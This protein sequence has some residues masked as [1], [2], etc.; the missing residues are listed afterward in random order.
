MQPLVFTGSSEM[1]F[2]FG[3]EEMQS[4]NPLIIMIFVPI[5]TLII[6][7]RIGRWAAPLRRMGCGIILAGV[8]YACVAA[9][10]SLL[11]AGYHL[12]ILWQSI[13]YLVLTFSE[14]LVSTT[15]LEYAYTAAGKNLKSI[16]SGF[17]FLTSTLGNFL[18][19]FLTA[20]VA[21]PASTSTFLI[22][23]SLS[24]GVGI[25]FFVVTSRNFFKTN[26]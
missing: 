5:V 4:V 2:S 20:L 23:A 22:Y 19:I 26:V 24:V 6:Y 10:Q 14:I 21:D 15:G 7:P 25:T 12:S 13:P 1:H 18:I 8:S 9:I 3:A 11:D 16:V 17:W